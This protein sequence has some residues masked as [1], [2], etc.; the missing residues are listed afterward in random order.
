MSRAGDAPDVVAFDFEPASVE[1]YVAALIEVEPEMSETRKR[2]LQIQYAAPGRT[3][4]AHRLAE[5][6]I[7]EGWRPANAQYGRLGRRLSEALG[8]RPRGQTA[9]HKGWW[10]VLSSGSESEEGFRWTMHPQL[11]EA[12]ERLGWVDAGLPGEVTAQ[13]STG[14]WEGAVRQVVVN[15]YERSAE[16]RRR[17]IE[18]FEARCYVC[19]FDFEAHYGQLDRDCLHVHHEVPL[20]EIRRSYRVDPIKD[21]KPVCPNCH[22]VIHSRTPPYTVEEVRAMIRDA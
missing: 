17:C 18:H 5:E 20:S 1:E 16:A 9:R 12:L 15:A 11:A 7:Y 4:T 2:L 10:A 21:L 14:L 3:V 22:A 19:G 13:E 8:R 6:M